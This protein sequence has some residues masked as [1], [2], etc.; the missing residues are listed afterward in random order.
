MDESA[1]ETQKV[2]AIALA[3]SLVAA[4]KEKTEGRLSVSRVSVGGSGEQ[5]RRVTVDDTVDLVKIV[6]V[7]DSGT[8]KSCLMLRFVKDEFVT[9]TRA[10]IGMDFA[11]RQ[12][13]V[14][15]MQASEQSV[16][17]R[18]TMQ[19]WDTAGQEQFHSLTSTY[20]RRAGGVMVVYDANRRTTFESVAYWLKDVDGNSEGLGVV[21]MLVAAKAEGDTEVPSAEG[22]ALA[23]EH[24]CL[25][26]ETSSRD[27]RGVMKAFQRLGARVLETQEAAE[28]VREEEKRSI[29]LAQKGGAK[30]GK[31]C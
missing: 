16:V 2:G 25:F 28:A 24:G 7:G 29:T 6:L 15:V 17:Q 5:G 1:D 3:V 14:D 19:V 21:K 30:K 31:C 10:T 13:S 26:M 22:A 9:S 27:N 12:I 23:A 20:Y 18:L 4:K 8:G 11:T